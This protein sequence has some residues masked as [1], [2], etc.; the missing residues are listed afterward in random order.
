MLLL[1]NF[2]K[3]YLPSLDTV[4]IFL[5]LEFKKKTLSNF[6]WW[7]YFNKLYLV[8]SITYTGKYELNLELLGVIGWLNGGKD[9]IFI[10]G[11]S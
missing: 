9:L 4:T 2:I 7:K 11:P 6:V 1:C 8:V 5:Y 10:W 3:Q